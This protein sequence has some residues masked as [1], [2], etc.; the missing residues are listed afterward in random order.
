MGSP[1]SEHW[2]DAI[3]FVRYLKNSLGQGILFRPNTKLKLTAWCDADWGA[4]PLPRR[5]LTGWFI[6]LGGSPLSWKTMKED[7]VSRSSAEAEYMAMGDTVCELIWIQELLPS[8]GIDRSGPIPLYSDSLSAI[9]LAANP[10]YHARTKQV[11]MDCH[12]IRDE[13]IKGLIATKHVSTKL[14]LADIMTKALGRRE[15]EDF[16]IKLGVCNLHTLP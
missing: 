1:R 4:C 3:R 11:G 7:R 9:N 16:L 8:F 10:V 15:F 12:F 6:Q 2:N 14:Q 5:S 13:I